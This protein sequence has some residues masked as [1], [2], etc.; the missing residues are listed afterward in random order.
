[1]RLDRAFDICGKRDRLKQ[2]QPTVHAPSGSMESWHGGGAAEAE[3]TALQDDVS[4]D[5]ARGKNDEPGSKRRVRPKPALTVLPWV[6]GAR[7]R[8]CRF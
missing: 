6:D 4:T 2:A 3:V 1:M 8:R 7:Q 5:S